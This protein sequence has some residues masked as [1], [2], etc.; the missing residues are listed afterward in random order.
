MTVAEHAMRLSKASKLQTRKMKGSRWG[1]VE[2]CE[3]YQTGNMSAL[4]ETGKAA[5]RR[6]RGHLGHSEGIKFMVHLCLSV[7]FLESEL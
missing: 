6:V 2:L 1:G 3:P 5:V 4:A 7:G